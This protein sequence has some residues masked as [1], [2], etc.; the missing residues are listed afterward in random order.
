MKLRAVFSSWLINGYN[1]GRDIV[2]ITILVRFFILLSLRK[3]SGY[4]FWT[5]RSQWILETE[6][7]TELFPWNSNCMRRRSCD[8]I[9]TTQVFTPHHSP[10]WLIP[11][12]PELWHNGLK[13]TCHYF[14]TLGSGTLTSNDVV[15]MNLID[16]ASFQIWVIKYNPLINSLLITLITVWDS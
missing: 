7:K 1:N 5:I 16:F 3:W 14:V 2:Y 11:G 6:N 10:K 8:I 15:C 4:A 13:L 12:M 9:C